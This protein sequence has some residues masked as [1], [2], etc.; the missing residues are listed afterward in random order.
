MNFKCTNY[1]HIFLFLFLFAL[2]P[3]WA[4]ESHFYRLNR[5]E[6]LTKVPSL[7]KEAEELSSWQKRLGIADENCLCYLEEISLSEAE[8]PETTEIYHHLPTDEHLSYSHR[9]PI[10]VKII[11][12]GMRFAQDY[13]YNPDLRSRQLPHG[14]LLK[15]AQS[16]QEKFSENRLLLSAKHSR[17]YSLRKLLLAFPILGTE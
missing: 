15:R 13:D 9:Q 7:A 11:G 5:E 16:T 4:L 6:F 8:R 3:S 2:A 17:S 10:A 1:R 12:E 14:F